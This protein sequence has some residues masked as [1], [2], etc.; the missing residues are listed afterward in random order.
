MAT[1]Q[2]V[3]V[4]ATGIP[5]TTGA[6]STG[7][8]IASALPFPNNRILAVEPVCT[9]AATTPYA[10]ITFGNSA[11]MT[12]ATTTGWPVYCGTVAEF[13]MGQEWSYISIYNA[14]SAN[15]TVYIMELARS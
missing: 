10:Q 8:A 14:S 7:T 5:T 6:I 13:D 15:M 2:S 1:Y 12:A 4:P 11:A 3:F 9:A